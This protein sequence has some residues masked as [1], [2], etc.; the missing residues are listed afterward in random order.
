MA[1]VSDQRLQSKNLNH[2]RHEGNGSS[3]GVTDWESCD[4]GSRAQ[5][6][7]MRTL[8]APLDLQFDELFGS[9]VVRHSEVY[10]LPCC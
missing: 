8:R 3:C 9:Y 2:I 5:D 1:G 6:D 4:A 7:D 10:S